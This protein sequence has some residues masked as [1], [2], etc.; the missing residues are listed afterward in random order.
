MQD[1]NCS[2]HINTCSTYTC[3]WVLVVGVKF[4]DEIY[5]CVFFMVALFI[6]LTPEWCLWLHLL[7]KKLYKIYYFTH[8]INSINFIEN[9]LYISRCPCWRVTVSKRLS[10]NVIVVKWVWFSLDAPNNK[11]YSKAK[12]RL[13]NA[14]FFIGFYPNKFRIKDTDM[15]CAILNS[16][17]HQSEFDTYSETEALILSEKNHL[18]RVKSF[19][20][21]I[22]ITI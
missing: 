1:S 22:F 14:Y 4:M 16:Y 10:V 3:M 9:F 6:Y 11:T 21:L 19:K 5:P 17:K 13:W 18:Y 8:W 2:I 20:T 7:W 12:S 15:G